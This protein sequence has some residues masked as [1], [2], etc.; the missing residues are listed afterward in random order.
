M[1]SAKHLEQCLAHSNHYTSVSHQFCIL[2]LCWE[3]DSF[4]VICFEHCSKSVCMV[5]VKQEFKLQRLKPVVYGKR[6]G[7][8]FS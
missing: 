5:L 6:T 4:V 3:M 1:S 2:P 8:Q 7:F